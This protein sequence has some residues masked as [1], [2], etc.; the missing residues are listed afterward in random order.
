MR[1]YLTV[2]DMRAVE[3][4]VPGIQAASPVLN[5]HQSFTSGGGKER[6]VLILE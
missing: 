6:D 1:D 2:D 5:L 4:Q 3:Q